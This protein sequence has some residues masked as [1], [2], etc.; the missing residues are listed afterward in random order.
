MREINAEWFNIVKYESGIGDEN[1]GVQFLCS[2]V[3]GFCSSWIL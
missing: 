3:E 2:Y 1:T